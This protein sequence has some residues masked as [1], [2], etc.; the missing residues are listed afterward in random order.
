VAAFTLTLHSTLEEQ[1]GEGEEWSNLL[2]KL[3][4]LS[5]FLLFDLGGDAA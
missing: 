5:L 4:S 3:N 2:E 1:T